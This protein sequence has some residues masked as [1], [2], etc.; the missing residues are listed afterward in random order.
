MT[1]LFTGLSIGLAAGISPGPLQTLV[2]TSTLSRGFGAGV[3]VGIAPLIS[4]TPIVGLSLVAVAAIPDRAVRLLAIGGGVLVLAM[5]LWELLSARSAEAETDAGPTKGIGDLMRG[6][7]VNLISPHP[8][9]FWVT[10]GAPLLVTA[11]R[12]NPAKAVAFLA[13]FYVTLL[14]SKIALAGVV[15]VGRSRLSGMWRR[16]LVLAGGALLVV[17]GVLLI[18]RAW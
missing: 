12:A 13:G 18:V 16:R 5:G 15:A 11:W 14:G 3:R 8:W 6:G 10:A 4:D 9:L 7:L 17:G 1:E 2:V